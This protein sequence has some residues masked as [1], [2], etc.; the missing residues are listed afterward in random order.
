MRQSTTTRETRDLIRILVLESSRMNSELLADA[1]MHQDDR[2]KVCYTDTTAEFLLQ[3][4][5][6]KPH[7]TIISGQLDQS[8]SKGFSVAQQ[9]RTEYPDV[10]IILLLDSLKRDL[11]LAAFRTGVSGVFCRAEPVVALAKCIRSVHM[12][13]IWASSRELHFVIEA[14]KEIGPPVFVDSRDQVLLSKREREV[15]RLTV[16]GM[17]N[18]EVAEK[19]KL[20]EHTVKNYLRNVFDK[21]GVSNRVELVLYACGQSGLTPWTATVSATSHD[22][23]REERTRFNCYLQLAAQGCGGAQFALAEMYR[24]GRGTE[25]DRSSAYAWFQVAENN[26]HG[27]CRAN[28]AVREQLASQMTSDQISRA[29]QLASELLKKD[30]GLEVAHAT[31]DQPAPALLSVRI[32]KRP[33]SVRGPQTLPSSMVVE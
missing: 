8:A 12:G 10:R 21:L 19:M 24:D 22:W 5:S 2:F 4:K 1:L 13:Q 7:V 32:G 6:Q 16:A 18:A 23:D 33:V 11:V 15:V 25:Q 29:R 9:L 14:L 26:C 3:A 28:P 30:I 27:Q 20:S 17:T 31:A